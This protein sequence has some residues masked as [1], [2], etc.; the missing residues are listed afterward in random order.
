MGNFSRQWLDAH[1]EIGKELFQRIDCVRSAAV[2][3][4]EH[5][6]IDAR[7]DHQV[8]RLAVC[9]RGD[10][11]VVVRIICI[12]ECDHSARVKNDGGGHLLPF[13][14]QLLEVVRRIHTRQRTGV[15]LEQ[16]IRPHEHDAA[17]PSLLDHQL[18]SRFEAGT[19]HCL[20]RNGGLVLPADARPPPAICSLYFF[21]RK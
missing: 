15:A 13:V 10:C 5:F 16:I 3:T 11:L 17:G 21:H 6:G 12:Q 1:G 19:A 14:P 9:E 8:V 20:H 2:R 4:D 18:I 7:R